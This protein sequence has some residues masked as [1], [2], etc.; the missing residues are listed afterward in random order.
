MILTETYIVFSGIFK[1]Y[2]VV[3]GFS[4]LCCKAVDTAS[5][6]VPD[7][8]FRRSGNGFKGIKIF[9]SIKN[10]VVISMKVYWIFFFQ[11]AKQIVKKCVEISCGLQTTDDLFDIVLLQHNKQINIS[12]YRFSFSKAFYYGSDQFRT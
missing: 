10:H 1:R 8:L 9:I 5:A 12:R 7:N 3:H 6:C 2:Q 11:L 4:G